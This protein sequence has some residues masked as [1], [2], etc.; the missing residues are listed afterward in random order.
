MN[1]W[2]IQ[3]GA[4]LL[5]GNTLN[6]FGNNIPINLIVAVIAEVVLVGGAEYYRIINGLVRH[7]F[8]N[9]F[10]WYQIKRFF[11]SYSSN[12]I[13]LDVNIVELWGQASPRR[14]IRPIGVSRRPRP[15]SNLEGERDQEWKIG[16]VCNAR[17]LLPS[18]C[19]RR[20]ASGEFGKA[21][22][23]SFWKQSAH[24]HFRECWKSSNSL[25]QWMNESINA[26]ILKPTTQSQV[27]V[28]KDEKFLN[29]F[30]N[31]YWD[32]FVAPDY[33]T[34]AFKRDMKKGV[35]IK[36]FYQLLW[37]EYS[38]YPHWLPA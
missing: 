11:Y 26:F 13:F 5:D 15:G 32:Y 37:L 6:Y 7:T 18:I 1:Y 12:D 8:Y 24:S 33:S 16:N 9:Y 38:I 36:F 29:A 31:W 27:C 25:N 3:T 34:L 4:L 10:T 2:P 23:W 21:F 14:A 20:R 17:V 30:V 22:E 35:K 28:L 19:D